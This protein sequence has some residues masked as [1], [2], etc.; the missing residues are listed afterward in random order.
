M[1]LVDYEDDVFV[2]LTYEE[3]QYLAE[4]TMDLLSKVWFD[5][6]NC[7]SM[8][9]MVNW[10][11]KLKCDGGRDFTG[12][13]YI[14]LTEKVADWN[15]RYSEVN[16]VWEIPMPDFEDNGKARETTTRD[17]GGK[18]YS[19]EEQVK[20]LRE[21]TRRAWR[22]VW[23]HHRI[24]GTDDGFLVFPGDDPAESYDA[25]QVER[26]RRF[27]S[28]VERRAKEWGDPAR[29]ISRS[30]VIKAV[31]DYMPRGDIQMPDP[32]DEGHESLMDRME[33]EYPDP[34]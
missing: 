13:W 19:L 10:L 9:R 8:F 26:E 12:T 22:E 14:E 11:F 30:E 4:W 18:K 27:W 20:L 25:V 1:K 28:E 3:E 29:G 24:K 33:V 5:K 34:D 23:L 31:S 6:I 2:K 32:K 7:G 17:G 16:K 21:E 15:E